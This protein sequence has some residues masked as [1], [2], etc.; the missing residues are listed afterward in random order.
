MIFKALLFIDFRF[1]GVKTF[2]FQPIRPDRV[3]AGLAKL[4]FSRHWGEIDG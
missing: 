4:Q 3:G 1:T 2:P